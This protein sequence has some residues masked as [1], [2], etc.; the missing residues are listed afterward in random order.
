MLSKIEMIAIKNLLID[1]GFKLSPE[2]K[3]E[4]RNILFDLRRRYKC[5]NHELHRM[6]SEQLNQKG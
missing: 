6:F 1:A 2:E 3:E 5:D 4:Q